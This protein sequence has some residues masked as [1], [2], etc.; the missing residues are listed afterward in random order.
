MLGCRARENNNNNNTECVFL[1][2]LYI[3]RLYLNGTVL[4]NFSLHVVINHF[5]GQIVVFNI[6]IINY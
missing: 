1:F 2:H 5:D 3:T 4:Y 6:K